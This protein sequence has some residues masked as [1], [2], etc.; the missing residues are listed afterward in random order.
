[1]GAIYAVEFGRDIGVQD[2]ILEGDSLIVVKTLQAKTENLSPYR[3]LFFSFLFDM[4][5]Q[6]RKREIRTSDL[7]FMRRGPNRLSYLMRRT[8]TLLKTLDCS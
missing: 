2:V 1:M 8:D 4:S 6:E 3:H 5:T 7:R